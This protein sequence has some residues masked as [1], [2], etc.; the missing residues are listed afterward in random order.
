M[1]LKMLSNLL[2]IFTSMIFVFGCS[3]STKEQIIG[4]W[5]TSEKGDSIEYL[6]DGTV[7]VSSNGESVKGKWSVLDDGRIRF[8][9]SEEGKPV[10]FNYKVSFNGKNEM[11]TVGE[12]NQVVTFTRIKN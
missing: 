1:K 7:T 3:S 12:K 10:V 6:Q 9:T 4:K 5:Q 8:E 2:I 11:I